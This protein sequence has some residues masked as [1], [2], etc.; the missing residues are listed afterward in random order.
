MSL[1]LR[2]L[3]L[4]A[5]LA[6]IGPGHA[7]C[8][9]QSAPSDTAPFRRG[10]W[11]LQFAGGSNFAGLGAL[12]FTSPRSAWLLDFQFSGGH[13]H[14]QI[15]ISPDS[16]AEQFNSTA[17]FTSR[18]GKRFYQPRHEVA[19]YQT[20]GVLGGFAHDCYG[21]SALPLGSYCSNG[22]TAGAFGEIGAAYLPTPHLSLGGALGVSFAY[23]R[24][25]YGYPGGPT[26]TS[27]SYAGTLGTL[28]LNVT[29]YF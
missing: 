5:V 3:S 2:S 11:A 20:L 29:L 6:L 15:P 1:I 27:W 4:P 25:R 8:A 23:A 17:R 19:S 28:S 22:W 18:A 7:A 16:V 21:S 9:Q 14:Q 10:Q 26:T 13:S 12:K 24:T